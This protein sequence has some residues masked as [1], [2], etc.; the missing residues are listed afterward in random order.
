MTANKLNPFVARWVIQ[1]LGR[2]NLTFA[3][4]IGLAI[5]LG[6]RLRFS[7]PA[8]ATALAYPGAPTSWG[9]I[10]GL[11][12]LVGLMASITARV[13]IVRW[14][15]YVVAVWSSFFA[16]S[17]IDSAVHSPVAGIT[18]P[19]MY[20]QLAIQSIVLAVAHKKAD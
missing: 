5:I 8:Y 14:S 2:L 9:V 4:A 7:G 6:G 12:G 11:T 13:D 16:Y 3:I 18:G 15:L 19:F 17:F 1:A 10:I 20:T